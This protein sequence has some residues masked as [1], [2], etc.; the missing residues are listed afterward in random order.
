MGQV[1]ASILTLVGAPSKLCLGRGGAGF[2]K[3]TL[4]DTLIPTKLANLFTLLQAINSIG[5][6]RSR[7]P[8]ECRG[9]MTIG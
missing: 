2:L 1:S 9:P 4:K 6:N 5:W 3:E 7:S 8:I